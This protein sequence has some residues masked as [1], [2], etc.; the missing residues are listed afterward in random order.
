MERPKPLQ[1]TV[2]QDVS[3]ESAPPPPAEP[4]W[5]FVGDFLFYLRLLARQFAT[6]AR[7]QG[8]ER[9]NMIIVPD[10]SMAWDQLGAG[11]TEAVILDCAETSDKHL[12][13]IRN[14][15]TYFPQV[16]QVLVSAALNKKMEAELMEAG[17][18][19][20]FSKPRTA[21]EAGSVYQLVDALTNSD[22]FYPN[23]SFKGLAPARF[24]QFLCARGESGCVAMDTEKGEAILVMENGRIVDAEVGDVK[25]DEAAALILS[26][27]R[28]ERCHFKHMQTSQFHTIKLDTHQLWLDSDKLKSTPPKKPEPR[29]TPPA[30][31]LQEAVAALDAL[32]KMAFHIHLEAPGADPEAPGRPD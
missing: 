20:C 10:V 6:L 23:G 26:L 32:D 31:T 3:H 18:H 13:F 21:D 8:R 5:L 22:G 19:L 29:Q 15:R 1:P 27:D 7:S 24:I 30:K 9:K 16:R 2:S 11:Q 28:T 12:N 14:V 4:T 17:A 25:G